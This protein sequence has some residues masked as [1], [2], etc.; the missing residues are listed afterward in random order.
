M[1]HC[2]AAADSA[3]PRDTARLERARA[4]RRRRQPRAGRAPA[5]AGLF[6][7][8]NRKERTAFIRARLGFPDLYRRG[9]LI[10]GRR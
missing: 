3:A 9:L 2:D 10:G 7:G 6:D 5:V 4:R 8:V 1:P